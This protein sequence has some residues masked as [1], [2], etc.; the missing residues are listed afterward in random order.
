MER[1]APEG[2][3]YQAGT[4]SGNPLAMAAGLATLKML[5][6]G[7][8]YDKLEEKGNALFSGLE[9]AATSAGLKIAVNRMGSMGCL[10]FSFKPLG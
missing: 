5:Q 7:D 8:I 9:E 3:I 6:K 4:L 10:F 2:D 1:M